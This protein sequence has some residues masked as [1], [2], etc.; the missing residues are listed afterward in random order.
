MRSVMR[1]QMRFQ[2]RTTPLAPHGL[3][4]SGQPPCQCSNWA[5]CPVFTTCQGDKVTSISPPLSKRILHQ[6][7]VG[8]QHNRWMLWLVLWKIFF[9]AEQVKTV[10]VSFHVRL[11]DTTMSCCSQPQELRLGHRWKV[12]VLLTGNVVLITLGVLHRFL[13]LKVLYLKQSWFLGNNSALE[14]LGRWTS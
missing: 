5:K 1:F 10:T 8:T 3:S 13:V 14:R 9:S 6:R 4:S 7:T 12:R 11:R 2:R